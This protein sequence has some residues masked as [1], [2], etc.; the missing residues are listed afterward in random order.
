MLEDDFSPAVIRALSLARQLALALRLPAVEPEHLFAAILSDDESAATTLLIRFGVCFAELQ[1]LHRVGPVAESRDADELPL[2]QVVKAIVH[3]AREAIAAAGRFEPVGSEDLLVAT[4]AVWPDASRNLS[5]HG[6][7]CDRLIAEYEG[8][9]QTRLQ[10]IAVDAGDFNPKRLGEET[11]LAR[12]LDANFNRA[13]EALRAVE[14]YAR[15]VR[16][17]AVL[18]ARLKECRHGLREALSRLPFALLSAARDTVGDV[19]VAIQSADEGVRS[20]LADVVAANCKRGQE[21]VR[22][23][24]EYSK[25]ESSEAAAKFEKIRYE[26]YT[27]EKLLAIRQRADRVL[28]G[29]VLYWLADPANCRRD[30]LWTVEQALEG[31]VQI[32]QLRDKS[33]SDRELLALALDVRTLTNSAKALFIVNDRP[34]IVRLCE[35]DGVHLGQDDL[36]IQ[37]A[38]RIVG[39]DALIGISTHTEEQILSAMNAGADYIGVGPVFVSKTKSFDRFPGLDLVAISSRHP[40]VPAYCI[41]GIDASNLES[42]LQAGG[43]RIAVANAIS[44]SDD[45]AQSARQLRALLS[46]PSAQS[47]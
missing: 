18:S 19:G 20:S 5:A 28:A 34:D 12:I 11:D 43:S 39:P 38:R 9:R 17:D 24:E 40:S 13:R 33:A 30:F 25:I 7:D 10:S 42:V 4:I 44:N 3:W 2:S 41:G 47:V 16:N 27:V 32:V 26:L 22:T 45:P 29:E 1:S 37:P 35:A 14:D 46:G 21:A 8:R 23:L 15:F 36:P 31:G 6:C